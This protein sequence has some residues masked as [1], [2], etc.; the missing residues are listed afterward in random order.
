[1]TVTIVAAVLCIAAGIEFVRRSRRPQ[2]TRI[3]KPRRH[4]R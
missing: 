4:L 2:R 3:T 1:M